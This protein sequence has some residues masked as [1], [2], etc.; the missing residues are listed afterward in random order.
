MSSTRWLVATAPGESWHQTCFKAQ[1]TDG[2]CI[3]SRAQTF[4]CLP[5]TRR[6]PQNG[7]CRPST[8]LPGLL[9]GLPQL[10]DHWLPWQDCGSSSSF[11]HS[12]PQESLPVEDRTRKRFKWLRG[13]RGH[14]GRPRHGSSYQPN[15][16]WSRQII[17]LYVAKSFK[18]VWS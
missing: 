16:I 15:P 12:P 4:P 14:R 6:R 8:S 2:A 18:C 10:T 9:R 3:C 13:G 17:A 7:G 1:Q 11:T 5:R